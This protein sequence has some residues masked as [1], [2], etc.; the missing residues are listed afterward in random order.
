VSSLDPLGEA[1][2][3]QR[4]CDHILGFRRNADWHY[5]LVTTEEGIQSSDSS[6]RFK[7]CPECG[8]RL[9]VDPDVVFLRRFANELSHYRLVRASNGQLPPVFG[10]QY[11]DHLFQIS[12]R[13]EREPKG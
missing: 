6:I 5:V 11:D 8:E 10:P 1:S 9:D 4:R 3:A 12:D 2:R 7:C 13:L